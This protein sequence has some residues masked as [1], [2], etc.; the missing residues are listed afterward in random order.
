MNSQQKDQQDN[1]KGEDWWQ[2][3]DPEK[4][5]QFLAQWQEWVVREDHQKN[6]AAWKTFQEQMMAG[7]ENF[8]AHNALKNKTM[9]T[10]STTGTTHDQQDPSARGGA[11]RQEEHSTSPDALVGF[12][13]YLLQRQDNLEERIRK[14]ENLK[15]ES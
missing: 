4:V 12:V 3:A 15:N 10:S 2:T 11:A 13:L 6:L 5:S 9:A 7:F 1:F 8:W 14:L